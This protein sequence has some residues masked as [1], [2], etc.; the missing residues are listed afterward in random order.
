MESSY[1]YTVRGQNSVLDTGLE[2]SWKTNKIK[3][4]LVFK[5]SNKIKESSIKSILN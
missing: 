2:H 1:V 5:K 3:Q 4:L